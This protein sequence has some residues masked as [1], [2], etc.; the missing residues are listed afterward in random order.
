MSTT[1]QPVGNISYPQLFKQLEQQLTSQKSPLNVSE[2]QGCLVGFCCG[3]LTQ[4][5]TEWLGH[6]RQMIS[7]EKALPESMI[8]NLKQLQQL[9]CQQLKGDLFDLK[10]FILDD[11]ADQSKRLIS[12]VNWCEGWLLGFGLSHGD[13]KLSAEAREGLADIRDISQVETT[14]EDENDDEFEKELFAVTSHI[15]VIVEMIFLELNPP[16]ES[17][18]IINANTQHSNN[19]H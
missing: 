16:Q 9:I 7:E 19:I 17:P 18:T 10:L 12:V 1:E 6:L 8:V 14:T 11:A 2:I 3:G 15:K 5:S 4:E 13:R